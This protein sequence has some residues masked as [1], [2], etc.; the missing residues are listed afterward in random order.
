M[1]N[2]R[3]VSDGIMKDW[4]MFREENLSL[5]TCEEDKKYWI[6]FDEI[7]EKIL[8]N[9][10]DKNKKY[11]KKQLQILDDNFLII[12]VI[13]MKSIIGMGL[14]MVLRWLWAL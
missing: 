14:L 13:G 2:L 3:E 7:S 5:L 9:V 8:R 1:N 11:V 10:P 12:F 4:L 6:Y